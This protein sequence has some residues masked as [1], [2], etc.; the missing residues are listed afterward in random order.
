MCALQASTLISD[1]DNAGAIT[2]EAG[3]SSTAAQSSAPGVHLPAVEWGEDEGE[4][5]DTSMARYLY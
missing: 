2:D 3:P 5:V 4:P 1:D